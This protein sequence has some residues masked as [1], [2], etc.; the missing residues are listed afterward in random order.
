[1]S[2]ARLRF[3]RAVTGDYPEMLYFRFASFAVIIAF[4]ALLASRSTQITGMA[5]TYPSILIFAVIVGT[6]ALAT[7]EF[8][9]RKVLATPVSQD[10][11]KIIASPPSS[12]ARFAGF[13][14]VW[15]AFPWLLVSVG[16]VV[17]TTITISASFWLLKFGRPGYGIVGAALFSL[18]CAVLCATVFYIPLPPGAIDDWIGRTLFALSK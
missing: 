11:A 7:K 4:A 18:G 8:L 15:L 14:L 9:G 1:M 12:R 17:A 10:V 5:R 6:L 16:F 2:G 3:N 13:V